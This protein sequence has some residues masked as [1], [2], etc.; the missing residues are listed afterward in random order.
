[1]K[2]HE[3]KL[4][5]GN[6]IT[7]LIMDDNEFQLFATE[8]YS[9]KLSGVD[10]K[11]FSQTIS[12]IRLDKF[13]QRVIRGS[14]TEHLFKK[15]GA[16]TPSMTAA[17]R[18]AV[19]QTIPGIAPEEAF[20]G[21]PKETQDDI[22]RTIDLIMVSSDGGS[23]VLGHYIRRYKGKNQ[24]KKSR[25]EDLRRLEES[26]S[27]ASLYAAESEKAGEVLKGYM[28]QLLTP[29]AMNKMPKTTSVDEILARRVEKA[30]VATI[31][32]QVPHLTAGAVKAWNATTA[33]DL[34][35]PHFESER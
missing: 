23:A 27:V 10:A 14:A 28:R 34:D 9:L 7:V 29:I 1:M 21:L 22:N 33:A 30:S 4:P 8:L 5:G 6:K 24:A 20:G 18:G 15:Y 19:T 32:E 26:I 25:R 2:S 12:R 3:F 17:I 35:S 16:N 11:E 13:V 31:D